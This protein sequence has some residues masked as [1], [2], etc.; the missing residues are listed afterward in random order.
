MW[1]TGSYEDH[2]TFAWGNDSTTIV[3]PSEHPEWQTAYGFFNNPEFKPPFF[4]NYEI[5]IVDDNNQDCFKQSMRLG[6]GVL[7]A[8]LAI[9]LTYS[10]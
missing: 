7:T 6:V 2:N 9:F 4:K 10:F 5:V 8:V 1:I 3:I